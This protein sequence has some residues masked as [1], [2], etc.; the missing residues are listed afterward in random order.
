MNW[1]IF[2]YVI[3]FKLHFNFAWHQNTVISI[4]IFEGRSLNSCLSQITVLNI[5]SVDSV[6]ITVVMP[7]EWDKNVSTNKKTNY[8]T[9]HQ[10]NSNTED[11]S[12]STIKCIKPL[13]PK[14]CQL[15]EYIPKF[16]SVLWYLV[17]YSGVVYRETQLF[18]NKLFIFLNLFHKS[19][20]QQL[21]SNWLFCQGTTSVQSAQPNTFKSWSSVLLVAS[22]WEVNE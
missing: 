2:Y 1:I 22:W 9:H 18:L 4:K 21:R 5:L 8:L 10:S 19:A 6:S 11:W 20:N 17:F 3:F 13:R 12:F 14:P 16:V 15:W 7:I